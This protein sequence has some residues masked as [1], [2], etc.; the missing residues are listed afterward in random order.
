M[1]YKAG[2]VAVLSDMRSDFS[3]IYYGGF[4]RT[5]G[6]AGSVSAEQVDSIWEENILR[7]IHPDDLHEKYLQELRFLHWISRLPEKNRK[8]YYLSSRL[9]M[10]DASGNYQPALHRMFYVPAP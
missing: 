5:L 2:D 4:A 9:R 6:L 3:Y 10:R 7:L 8:D 1:F